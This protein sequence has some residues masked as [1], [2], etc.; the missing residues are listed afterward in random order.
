[1]DNCFRNDGLLKN[2]LLEDTLKPVNQLIRDQS[3]LFFFRR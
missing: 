3:I 1:M 2:V